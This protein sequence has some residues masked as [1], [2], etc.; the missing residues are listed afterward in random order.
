MS[1]VLVAVMSGCTS[2]TKV[3]KN[4][5]YSYK[6]E[7]AKQYYMTGNY[8]NAPKGNT[9]TGKQKKCTNVMYVASISVHIKRK[10]MNEPDCC[11]DQTY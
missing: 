11:T 7:K 8:K 5:D 6:F 4:P 2:A 1:A 3:L 9:C 10:W